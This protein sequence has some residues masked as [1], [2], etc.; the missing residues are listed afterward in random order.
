MA[1]ID[2]SDELEEL[3]SDSWCRN[4]PEYM[5]RT[6]HS[7]N[8]KDNLSKQVTSEVA[9]HAMNAYALYLHSARME[10]AQSTFGLEVAPPLTTSSPVVGPSTDILDDF[11]RRVAE[12]T[13]RYHDAD[14]KWI[15]GSEIRKWNKANRGV[16]DHSHIPD[17]HINIGSRHVADASRASRT[18][19]FLA[20]FRNKEA[21]RLRRYIRTPRQSAKRGTPSDKDS[22]D[23]KTTGIDSPKYVTGISRLDDP[24]DLDELKNFTLVATD[25]G[26]RTITD[27]TN[28]ASLSSSAV[29]Q[30]AH[31][32]DIVFELSNFIATAVKPYLMRAHGIPGFTICDVEETF[33]Q[34]TDPTLLDFLTAMRRFLS[35]RVVHSIQDD[36]R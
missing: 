12:V 13:T 29:M 35:S 14:N 20:V 6:Y 23:A 24:R 26:T 36:N 25:S 9:T 28:A 31:G 15:G 10:A 18:G 1:H 33:N 17:I 34:V 5:S 21:G 2:I 11:W 16:G 3:F 22:Q 8:T 30:S 27:V 32:D 7:A 19:Y 4:A